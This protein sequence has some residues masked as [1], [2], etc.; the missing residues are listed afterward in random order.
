M[1]E[2]KQLPVVTKNIDLKPLDV[3]SYYGKKE[4]KMHTAIR[5]LAGGVNRK[6]DMEIPVHTG[7]VM[8]HKGKLVIAEMKMKGSKDSPGSGLKYN[9]IDDDASHIR[10]VTRFK[11][12]EKERA[13]ITK[14]INN[15]YKKNNIRY[16]GAMGPANFLF[17]NKEKKNL[18]AA[19]CSEYVARKIEEGSRYDI[20]KKW[21]KVMPVDL[22]MMDSLEINKPNEKAI[23]GSKIEYI[24]VDKLISE[25]FSKVASLFF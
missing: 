7:I 1:S 14:N 3:V 23:R 6:K 9:N 15:D 17:K 24:P 12:N 22:A 10:G 20:T 5:G 16:L 13:A 8:K 25:K 4:N 18:K 21:H 11:L 19:I 2:Y